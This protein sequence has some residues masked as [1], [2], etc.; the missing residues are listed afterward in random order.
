M[1]R[2][3][4]LGKAW[5][6]SLLAVAIGVV[7]CGDRGHGATPL[8][9]DQPAKP[10]NGAVFGSPPSEDRSLA[11]ARFNYPEDAIEGQDGIIYVSDTQ[12]HVIR[13]IADGVVSVFAGILMS[14]FNGD[15][16][17]LD[18]A[19]S[20]PTALLLTADGKSL[21]FAD[22]G[23]RLLRKIDLA[24][25]A[26]TTF[27]GRQA[28]N[29]LPVD[30]AQASSSAI[31]YVSTLKWDDQ[32]NLW[33]PASIVGAEVID[34]ALFYM[35][36]AGTL[37]R[38]A[39]TVP[40]TF[41]GVRDIYIG[42]SYIDF[43]RNDD[44][45][46]ANLDGTY[47]QTKL[48]SPHG[49]GIEPI[50]GGVLVGSHTTLIKLDDNLIATTV[51]ADF[52]NIS[53]VKKVANGY[54]LTDSDQGALYKFDGAVKTQL[55]GTSPATNGALISVIKYT[56]TTLLIL[57]NQRSQIH[58][59][60]L[61][62]E[63]ATVWAGNGNQAWASINV[64]KLTTSFYYPSS[65]AADLFGNVF[66]AEQHRIMK[67]APDGQMSLYAGYEVAGDQ[68]ASGSNARFRSIGGIAADGNGNLFVA[69]TYNNKIR[70]ISPQGIVTTFAGTGD[71]DAP[72]FGV[73]ATQSPLNRPGAALPLPDGSVLISDSWNNAV[74]KVGTD[75]V[76]RPFAGI[77]NR[78]GYQ[79][80]GT[81]AGD[82]GLAVNAGMNTPLGLTLGAD[83]TVFIT[84]QFNHRIRTVDTVGV[85]RTFAGNVQGY[86]PEGKS[87]NFPAGL[88]A[89]PGQLY[90]A[91]SGNRI[92]VR[93]YLN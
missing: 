83:G 43:T 80:G 4:T 68:D 22:S 13:K 90:V 65:I 55:T 19:I 52:A 89:L 29:S 88:L 53:N 87:L 62:T 33:F 11:D 75:G 71:I 32:G 41:I 84:D 81:F 24:S 18:T 8:T 12:S 21:L 2:L 91:D 37:R 20:L 5:A 54:L 23:N 38:M 77:P 44:Y 70:K 36:P 25:G 47:K 50:A 14:G 39:L 58:L 69:D 76:L 63:K 31:G 57:D 92:I 9:P 42:P 30:G 66:I 61:N 1:K 73:Q 10:L 51:A 40:G 6:A 48:A 56:S 46:R 3:G 16:Q 79:G 78:A 49:K 85:I 28:D 34:G 72:A 67:I 17:R 27:A 26:I 35:T 64:D 7:G 93:Y 45:Y 15:G 59:F 60:D 82:G 74:Y 86:A